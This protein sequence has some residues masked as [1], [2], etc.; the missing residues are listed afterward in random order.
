GCGPP[1]GAAVLSSFLFL[2]CNSPFSSLLVIYNF[3][4]LDSCVTT[5]LYHDSFSNQIVMTVESGHIGGVPAAGAAFGGA[6]NPEYVSDMVRHF[7]FYDGGGLDV[8]FLGAAEVDMNG[9][10]NVS[11]FKKTVGPGGF[12]NIASNTRKV[13]F[14]GT[15]TAGGL[16]TE[17]KDGQLFILNEGRN[18]KY[19][20][21][22]QQITFSGDYA[23]KSGQTVLYVTERAVFELQKEGVVM[24]EIAPGIDLKTQVLDVIDFDVKVSPK[25]KVMDSRIFRDSLMGL[26]LE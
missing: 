24:T 17:V 15:L 10:C 5:L 8:C 14:C 26:S 9:N 23:I 6:Y 12:I 21:R 18:K 2:R 13:V 22:V 7:D 16:K 20:K 11:K 1:Q 25:L 19:V 3:I 4:T